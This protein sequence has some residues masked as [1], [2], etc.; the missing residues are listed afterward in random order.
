MAQAA[1]GSLTR[2]MKAA[3][4]HLHSQSVFPDHLSRRFGFNFP[5]SGRLVGTSEVII[6]PDLRGGTSPA[7]D[8]RITGH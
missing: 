2:K 7:P 6:G 1:I 3:R 4:L 8:S 5:C